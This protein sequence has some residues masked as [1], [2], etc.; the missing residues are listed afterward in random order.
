MSLHTHYLRF[1]CGVVDSEDLPLNISR[2]TLQH[3]VTLEKIKAS[4]TKRV[5][6]ELKKKKDDSIEEYLKFWTNFGAALKEGLCE[7]T[8]EP[9][10]L[11]EVCMF[12]S[13]IH[14][15]MIS[16]DEYINNCKEDQKTIY[17][18]SGEDSK[19]LLTSPQIEGFLNKGIKFW[20]AQIAEYLNAQ[21]QKQTQRAPQAVIVNL[22]S[23]EYFKAVDR[24]ALQARV[25]ECVFEDFKGG[26][27]KIISFNAK[28]ARGL[29]ARY[30]VT[31]RVGKVDQLKKFNLEC[32]AYEAAA[33]EADRWVFRRKVHA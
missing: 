27:Y 15:K 5:L 8:T 19:K 16:F 22:A 4:I 20:G 25:V 26:K 32:Y 9:E 6:S 12:R 18:L 21:L 2:E 1:I 28:R 24:K 23:Q 17:Y 11:L 3:N 31:Q 30:A 7:A 10:K 13:S 29:M 14:N 33:S